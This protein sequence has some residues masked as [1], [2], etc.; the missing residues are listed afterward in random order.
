MFPP[1]LSPSHI[2]C[3]PRLSSADVA[4]VLLPC[5]GTGLMWRGLTA[6]TGRV[7]FWHRHANLQN[8]FSFSST[9]PDRLFW[10]F[11]FRRA[12]T[13]QCSKS[14][15]RTQALKIQWISMWTWKD[16]RRL[17]GQVQ[18]MD[19]TDISNDEHINNR[20]LICMFKSSALL[21]RN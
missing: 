6:T 17:S 13:R 10:F 4:A 5:E 15:V 14:K 9:L 12:E 11:F 16:M 2:T 21:S 19:R 3:S 1:L 18:W 8:H 20:S 7:T